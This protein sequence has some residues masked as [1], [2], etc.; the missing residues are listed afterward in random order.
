MKTASLL[1]GLILS[2]FTLANAQQFA[3]SVKHYGPENGLSH[4]EVNAISQDKQGFMWFGTK[5]GLN[6]FDGKTFTTFTKGHNGFYFD[7]IQSI[8]RDAD[9]NLWLM[10]LKSQTNIAVFNP[11]TNQSIALKKRF[12]KQQLPTSFTDLQGLV[13]SDNGTIY[14]TNYQ[15]AAL[16][17]YHPTSGLRVVS[18]PQFKSLGTFRATAHNT[19][20]AIADENRLVEL[21]ADGRILRQFSH[22]KDVVSWCLGKRNAGIEFFYT[23]YNPAQKQRHQ[24]FSVDESGHRR[25]WSSV[26]LESMKRYIG[27][28]CYPF[29]RTGLIWDGISLRDS[30]NQTLLTIAGQTSGETIENRSF[31]RDRS[32][33]FWLG[34]SFGV[35][36]VKLT[37]NHFHRFF[38]QESNKAEQAATRGITVLGDQ[39]F[40]NLEKRGL[41]AVPGAGG[42]P[43]KLYGNTVF[44]YGLASDGQ[45]EIYA[46]N[47]NQL[48]QYNS[49]SRRSST[50]PLSDAS[51]IWALHPLTPASWLVG[52][53][54]GLRFVDT[55]TGQSKPFTAYHQFKEL[56]QAHVLHI[57]PDRQGTIWLG[58]NTG[59]YVVDPAR[60]ITARYWSGGKGGFYL[61][62]DNFQHVYQD[63]KGIYW[64][65]TA[66]AGLIRWDRPK[67]RFR[68]FRRSE[69][70]SND[71]IYAIYPDR[72]GNLWMSSDY[73]IM[74]F[75]PV[76][77]TTRTYFVQ[78]GIT[79][80]EF[81]RISHFQD[82]TG[83]IYFGGLNGITAFDPR[84]LEA[85]K[86]PV[87]LP[88]R[89]VGFRQFD[90][91]INQ[92]VDKTAD[93]NQTHQITIRPGDQ[94]AVLDFALLNYADAE[95]NVYA[96]HFK[97]LDNA[98]THQAESSLR[99]GNLP[100]GTYQL[101]IK[102]QASNG[103]WSAN[104]LTIPIEVLRPFYLQIWFMILTV[105]LLIGGI[106]GWLRWRIWN[107]QQE[108][109]RLQTEIRQAT[110]QIQDDKE[111]I[112]QQAQVLQRLN[113]TK[114]RF[115][116][117]ISHEFR[118]P[119]TVI[120]GMSSELKRDEPSNRIRQASDLI[121]RNGSN[122]L[123]LINQILDLSKLEAGEM[124]LQPVRSDLVRFS[125]Y[126]AESFQS[127]ADRKAIQLHFRSDVETCET[128]FDQDKLQDIL[129]N[130]L[131]NAL[132][133]A[134]VG[135]DV[136]FHLVIHDNWNPPGEGF[137]EDISP[138]KHRSEPWF[139]IRVRDTGPGIEPESLRHIFD[140]FFQVSIR[141]V[142]ETGG[143]GIGLSLVR[144]L[145]L[146]MNG[147]LAV[148]SLPG[149]GAEFVVSLPRTQKAPPTDV[150]PTDVATTGLVLIS[151]QNRVETEPEAPVAGDKPVLLLV[152]DND[153]VAT[154]IQS[155][156][157]NEY[158]ILRGENGQ[159]GID[160][161]F[162][163][164]PDL[165]L[166]DVMMPQKD[167]FQVCDELKNDPRTSHIPIVLLTA[168]AAAS[169]RISGLRRGADA[170]LTK[171]FQREELRVVLENQLQ[172][173]RILQAHY[174]QLALKTGAP[175]PTVAEGTD[176]L[177]NL[178]LLKLRTALEEQ[179]DNPDFSI[180]AICQ[181]M[182]MSRSTLHL[183]LVALTGMSTTRYIRALRLGKAKELL[184]ASD[185]NISEVAYAVGF[186]DPKYFSRVFSDE[187]GISPAS[188]RLSGPN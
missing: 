51:S 57:A 46:G 136:Y 65:A 54:T 31:Y 172:S 161:A 182:R 183:K 118:T 144:E 8:A 128:D 186:E 124:Q 147:G 180:E 117:N 149:E 41:F 160:L 84:D 30:T 29:D 77:L 108:Q 22:G 53:P 62:A 156:L 121:E 40:A 63:A 135:G 85:E 4:R 24:F 20:W 81:N 38:Y 64:L 1:T 113:E 185:L 86:P 104:T 132:K 52:T 109:K 61:P 155:C 48:V 141:P 14:L 80:N 127:M 83:R 157:G 70:L 78:D 133:F 97:G 106:W 102:G 74:R 89:I 171:P 69:G 173:R 44:A 7:D 36:Q 166:S 82:K 13:S 55:Q 96:Y 42:L 87:T 122:L 35:Y 92:I 76:R 94:T 32:G 179:L 105:L 169:D 151:P 6:R 181:R 91:N 9:G 158:R 152:E 19:V 58:S 178:F 137:Y 17:S 150:T 34:T 26:L 126:L 23:V 146:L 175:D 98:W 16:L 114:S 71:N 21:T 163:T 162:S 2:F 67:N 107:H 168:K 27:P 11:L 93:L 47:G 75:D 33:Q 95:K 103:Q 39:V 165:L 73:G 134:P 174:S 45:G 153:D 170:Y 140:R 184:A 120:L 60:G 129:S 176:P 25:E 28:V 143:T 112:A 99:L 43:K 164:I 88:M 154:Y 101:L 123:R 10:G 139:S 187:F 15:P 125:R 49:Q 167:G 111:I 110:A 119:L 138:T 159:T 131:T 3:A 68:R 177:E 66:N 50:I 72:R 90:Q 115:F 116:A 59:L 12:E 79:H 142:S 37:H 188:F 18:L 100:Y 56:A 130:L 145:V 148:R 5:F